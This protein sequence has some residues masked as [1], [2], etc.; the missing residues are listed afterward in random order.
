MSEP[1]RSR[2]TPLTDPTVSPPI[3]ATSRQYPP[4]SSTSS[5]NH[6]DKPSSIF[7]LA[8]ASADRPTL[9]NRHS[10][11]S[12][13]ERVIPESKR[14]RSKWEA[15]GGGL[16]LQRGESRVLL[17]LTLLGSIVRLWRIGRPSS[18][19]SVLSHSECET[20][21]GGVTSLLTH[22]LA[23]DSFDEVHFGG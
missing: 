4:P 23:F 12:K 22:S 14:I 16:N 15:L 13:P 3:G 9:T 19:V 1:L 11:S 2:R 20:C 18:V 21:R 17:G 6:H 10:S 5:S 7:S 8:S